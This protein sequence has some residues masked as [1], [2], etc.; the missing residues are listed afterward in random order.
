MTL[1]MHT[2]LTLTRVMNVVMA[3]LNCFNAS[4]QCMQLPELRTTDIVNFI[5]KY[6]NNLDIY[7]GIIIICINI[8]L[9]L[10]K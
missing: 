8:K 1:K 2:I 6:N 9:I 4:V 3:C 5:T 7:I 10:L